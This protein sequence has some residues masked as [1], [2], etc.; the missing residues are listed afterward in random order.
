M[1]TADIFQL[2]S[3][4]NNEFFFILFASSVSVFDHDFIADRSQVAG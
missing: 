3:Q 4:K 2:I 1:V